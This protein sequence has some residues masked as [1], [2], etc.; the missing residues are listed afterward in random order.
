VLKRTE[1]Q[2][3]FVLIVTHYAPRL[4]DGRPDHPAHRMVNAEN[5]LAACAATR[6]GAIL[7]GHL[8]HPYRV[9]VPDLGPEILCAGSATMEGRESFWLLDIEESGCR[10]SLG[11]WAGREYTVE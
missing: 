1:V 11:R 2:E 9:R 6:P 7:C 5:F 3:R 8:H 10:V 4:H